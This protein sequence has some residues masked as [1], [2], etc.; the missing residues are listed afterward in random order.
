MAGHI[1]L[2]LGVHGQSISELTGGPHW[3]DVPVPEQDSSRLGT[4]NV[5]PLGSSVLGQQGASVVPLGTSTMEG[6]TVSGYS[7]T[8]SPAEEELAL[9]E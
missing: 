5:D 4:G 2:S 3:I 7:V 1:Y 9:E 6:V 8:P